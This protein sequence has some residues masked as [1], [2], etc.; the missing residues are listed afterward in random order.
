VRKLDADK[1]PVTGALAE[2]YVLKKTE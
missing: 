2:N 1:Q